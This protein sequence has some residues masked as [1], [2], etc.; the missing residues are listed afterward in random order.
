[1]LF[2][3][4]IHCHVLLRTCF[5]DC[6]WPRWPCE[7]I[8]LIYKMHFIFLRRFLVCS[9]TS[10]CCS[11]IFVSIDD[12]FQIYAHSLQHTAENIFLKISVNEDRLTNNC[13]I[14]LVLLYNCLNEKFLCS[15]K[16][17]VYEHPTKRIC[18]L[19]LIITCGYE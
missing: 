3:T 10:T 14:W 16:K 7:V 15:Y 12:C 8:S 2:F 19:P 6:K 11:L 17:E 18:T 4:G 5:C 9:F 1:M 13:R